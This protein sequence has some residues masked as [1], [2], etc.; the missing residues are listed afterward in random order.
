MENPESQP[1]DDQ[2]IQEDWGD[3]GD[4]SNWSPDNECPE[5]GYTDGRHRMEPTPCPNA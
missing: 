2:P 5:C 1:D 4:W 3:D